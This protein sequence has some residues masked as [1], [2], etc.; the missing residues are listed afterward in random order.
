MGNAALLDSKALTKIQSIILIVVI[1]VATVGGIA[2]YI[3]DG[4][5]DQSS[6]T[7]K[8]GVLADLDNL[9]GGGV[10]KGAQL[11][12]EEINSNGGIF[13]RQL[14][15]I[16]ENTDSEGDVTETNLAL[17]R[18]ITYHKVDYVIGKAPG[19]AGLTIQDIA[20]EHKKIFIAVS[21]SSDTL[22]QRVVDDY[23]KYKYFFRVFQMNDTS[24]GKGMTDSISLAKE[25]TGFNKI[26]YLAEDSMWNK[27]VRDSLD[28]LLPE[29]YG[30]DLVYKGTFPPSA[31]FEFASYF[32]AAEA[33]GVEILI[34]LIVLDGGIPF[35]KEYYDR[36]S[37][38]VVYGG[39]LGRISLPES[40]EWVDGKCEHMTVFAMPI[41]AE[42]PLTNRTLSTREA[43]I[44][45]WGETPKPGGTAAY[46]VL[47]FILPEAL[48]RAGTTETEEVIKALEKT[49]TETSMARNFVFTSSHD[50]MYG[51]GTNDPDD[52]NMIATLFQWQN[53][54]LVPIYPM[55][56]M[57]EAG[58]TYTYP[59]WP[60]PWDEQ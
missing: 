60:G 33:A 59:D 38:M 15:V 27:G 16:G 9:G 30:F 18:L 23:N 14:E 56:I 42:Y 40:W 24:I 5:E 26:G 57:E 48:E 10:L 45:R 3:L 34:P 37:P 28:Y 8:I 22:T 52:D 58:A 21:G 47:R 35:A 13:G 4:G 54:E 39:A 49:S 6:E 2:A 31:T 12:V 17:T 36:Q 43:Y 46:D 32:A 41:T 19:Q 53:G 1:V 20:S 55:K 29:V 7:I 51:E 50:V 44:N 25:I 11:A